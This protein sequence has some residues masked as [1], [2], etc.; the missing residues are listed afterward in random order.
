MGGL[1]EMKLCIHCQKEIKPMER[2]IDIFADLDSSGMR[3]HVDYIHFKC[4]QTKLTI[5]KE[6]T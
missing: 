3:Q 6:N 1:G 5:I 2:Y 4:L